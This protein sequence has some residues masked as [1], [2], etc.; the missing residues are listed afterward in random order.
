MQKKQKLLRAHLAQVAMCLILGLQYAFIK[1]LYV[2]F[3]NNAFFVLALRF[4][5]SAVFLFVAGKLRGVKFDLKTSKNERLALLFYPSLSLFFQFLS[6]RTTATTAI[7]VVL[8]FSPLINGLVCAFF[9]FRRPTAKQ[10]L[11]LWLGALCAALFFLVGQGMEGFGVMGILWAVLSVGARSLCNVLYCAKTKK[12][13]LS[14]ALAQSLFALGVYGAL[15]FFFTPFPV[16]ASYVSSIDLEALWQVGYLGVAATGL[17][18]LLNLSSMDTLGP[19][20]IGVYSNLTGLI[21]FFVGVVLSGEKVGTLGVGLFLA[22][23]VFAFLYVLGERR[24]GKGVG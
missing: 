6:V 11:Y 5:V 13:P 8:A 3:E 20:A 2:R 7:S 9:P 23:L 17:L 15:S 24:K 12:D 14:F 16:L 19:V 1:G 4:L 22:V 10:T 18:A 21:A